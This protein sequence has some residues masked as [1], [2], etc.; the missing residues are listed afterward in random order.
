[1]QQGIE[2]RSTLKLMAL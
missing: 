2:K 1:L